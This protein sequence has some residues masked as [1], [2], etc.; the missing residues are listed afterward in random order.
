MTRV[1]FDQFSKGYLEELLA[2]FGRIERSLEIPGEPTFVDVYFAPRLNCKPKSLAKPPQRGIAS[3]KNT[4]HKTL[5]LPNTNFG[6]ST[7]I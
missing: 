1:P 6:N 5:L 2:P 3:P 7:S 4:R